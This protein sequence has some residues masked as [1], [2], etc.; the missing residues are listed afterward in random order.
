LVE[1]RF[2]APP[3][4]SDSP[5]I[6]PSFSS[7]QRNRAYWVSQPQE[8]VTLQPQEIRTTVNTACQENLSACHL[9]H[10]CHRFA[11]LV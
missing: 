7:G 5:L 4:T 6:S 1:I 11:A 3:G 8:S 9:G 10:A 2:K